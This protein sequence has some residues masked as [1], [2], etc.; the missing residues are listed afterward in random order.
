MVEAADYWRN[1]LNYRKDWH[2]YLDSMWS[3]KH[4]EGDT[5]GEHSHKSGRG[6]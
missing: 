4:S 2:I 6:K 1:D 3:N 5:T